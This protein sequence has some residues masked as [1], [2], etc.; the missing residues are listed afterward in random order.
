M[1]KIKKQTKTFLR[2]FYISSVVVFCLLFG[3]LAAA[4]AYESIR[5]IGFGE[6]RRAVEYRDGTLYLFDISFFEN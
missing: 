6:Y 4:K 3:L 2:S 5:L 1:I